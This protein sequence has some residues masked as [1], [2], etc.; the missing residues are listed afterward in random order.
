MVRSSYIGVTTN[1]FVPNNNNQTI[2]IWANYPAGPG[3]STWNLISFQNSGIGSA[4][5]LGFRG[6]DAVAWKWG[7][8]VLVDGGAAPS[9]NVWHYYVYTYDGTTSDL[10]Y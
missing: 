1:G 5:Q 4:I 3:G 8:T 7:G 6:G 10:L 9:A 2:S